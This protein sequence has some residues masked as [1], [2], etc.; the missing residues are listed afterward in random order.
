MTKAR[1]ENMFK[2]LNNQGDKA[3]IA[4]IMA[5]DGGLDKL[6]FQIK[7]LEAAGVDLIEIGI[8]FSDPAADG[9]VIQR[10]GIRS[11]EHNVS[12]RDILQKL[13]EIKDE[14]N[15]PY[16]LMTYYNPVFHYKLGEF[17]KDAS[18]AN[19]SGL[20]VPD[21]PLEEESELKEALK[22]TDIA[23]IRLATLTT[24]DDR[25]KRLLY[26]AEGFIY[27]VNV[28]GVTGKQSGYSQ[29]VFDN[30]SRIKDKSEVPV[31]A[32][33]GINSAETAAALGEHCDGVIV[34]S[35][36][37]EMFNSN[38]EEKIKNLIPKKVEHAK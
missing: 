34:G 19:V 7:T 10:A 38:Q 5:G 31:C 26:E 21:V 12:L 35:S 18:A 16:V 29:E 25:L 24:T 36:I 13:T 33:F 15:V 37:V 28:N 22:G 9:P 1:I 4:Y 11:L 30:L 2:T 8:P 3:F 20:I 14:I 32:G 27:A 17:A 23:I 6:A